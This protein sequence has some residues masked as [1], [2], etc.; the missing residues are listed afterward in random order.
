MV[1]T[2]SPP[3]PSPLTSIKV[4]EYIVGEDRQLLDRALLIAG[5]MQKKKSVI[6]EERR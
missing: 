4:L 6:E 2:P 3:L 5:P 1:K